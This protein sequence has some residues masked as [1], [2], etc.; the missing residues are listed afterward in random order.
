MRKIFALLKKNII[1]EKS[2][3]FLTFLTFYTMQCKKNSLKLCGVCTIGPKGQV[4][5]PKDVRDFMNIKVGDKFV[6][7]VKDEKYLGLI[8]NED[9]QEIKDYIE[10]EQK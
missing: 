5:I 2:F 8:Q 10:Y 1:I 3:T 6:I 7:V 4:L 9:I